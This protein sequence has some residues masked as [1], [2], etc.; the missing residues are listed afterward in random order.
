[1]N[2]IRKN[3]FLWR[4]LPIVV[5][6]VLCSFGMKEFAIINVKER[7][8]KSRA[9]STE[10]ALQFRKQERTLCVDEEME[11]MQEKMNIHN[12]ENKRV[13]RPEGWE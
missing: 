5:F 2:F 11:K 4:G 10:E 7:D 12:W 8:K 6:V 1:M 13:P 3:Q 9:L